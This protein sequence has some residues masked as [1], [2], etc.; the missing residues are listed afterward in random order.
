VQHARRAE[1]K[2][3]TV[4][5]GIATDSVRYQ[6]VRLD[7]GILTVSEDLAMPRKCEQIYHWIDSILAAAVYVSPHTTPAKARRFPR[8]PVIF[9]EKIERPL[10]EN[11]ESTVASID[12]WI[13]SANDEEVLD[14]TDFNG[15]PVF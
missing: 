6:F 9:K 8:T 14:V 1:S 5:Y 15:T 13:H 2:A 4:V 3:I 12:D 7:E 10:F 11:S